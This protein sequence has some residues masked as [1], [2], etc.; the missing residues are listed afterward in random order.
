MPQTMMMCLSPPVMMGQQP[1]VMIG[2]P[3]LMG[4]RAALDEVDE[5]EPESE[6]E[7][8]REEAK[9]DRRPLSIGY[10]FVGTRTTGLTNGH[11]STIVELITFG[12]VICA[13]CVRLED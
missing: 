12:D 5:P 9:L 4:D 10:K 13:R 7:R 6:I 1:N 2:Q 3:Q 8:R 11:K